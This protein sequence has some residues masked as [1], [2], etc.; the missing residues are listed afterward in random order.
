M[1][2]K[3]LLLLLGLVV[4]VAGT[5]AA[6]LL[7]PTHVVRGY[8]KGEAFYQGRPVSY[9]REALI[10]PNPTTQTEA[11]RS[12][13][14]GGEAAV[15]VLST[16]L[17]R[18]EGSS[19]WEATEVRWKAADLMGKLGLE[20]PEAV[21][22]LIQALKDDDLHVRTV[23]ATSLGALAS[24]ETAAQAVP[25]LTEL[26]PTGGPVSVAAARALSRF[27]PEARSAVPALLKLMK[28]GEESQVRWNAVRTLG[29]IGPGAREAVPELIA[30]LKDRD[31]HV[32]EHAAEALG[33]IGPEAREGVPALIEILK[34][35]IA[36]V[37]RDAA[38]SLGQIGPAA[39]VALPAL[40]GLLNDEDPQVRQA[41]TRA[42]RILSGESSK[43]AES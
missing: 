16:L 7:E 27:G 13:Q 1:N 6:A 12:L 15:P 22:P 11:A 10:N 31:D 8:L 26:L 39:K 37:R 19:T 30:A 4:L 42:L 32:R 17:S 9:W 35:P 41:A 28:E 25:A 2:R 24:A 18:A 43:K 34:D 3:R 21:P 33:D 5:A 20:T 36:R 40:K 14:Q 38:R 29:K 23:A